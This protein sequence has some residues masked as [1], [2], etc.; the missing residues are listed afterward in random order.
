MKN[1]FGIVFFL[2]VLAACSTEKP[3]EEKT[4]SNSPSFGKITVEDPALTALIDTNAQIE[5][6]DSGYVWAEGPLWLESEKKIIWSD[7]PQNTVYEWSETGG[8]KVY[9][10]PSGNT[11]TDST[12]EGANGLLLDNK[13]YLIL[14]QHG[15]R[16]VARMEAPVSNPTSQ[17][18]TIAATFDG[19]RFNSPNDAAFGPEEY[20]FFTDPPYGL[21]QQEN[22]PAKELDFQGVY[23]LSPSGEVTLL[24]DSLTRPNGIAFSRDYKT[25]YVANSDPDKA[26]W[27]A[28]QLDENLQFSTGK[29]FFDATDWV[30]ER[31]G[32]PD[33][34]KVH[35]NGTVFATGP[36]GV[37][38]F[39]PEGKHLGTIE[40]GTA[41]ANCAFD[42]DFQYLYMTAD[43]YM[44]R[45]KL[46]T[47]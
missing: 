32:L 19:K 8:T 45:L 33:G 36:G 41:I 38:V 13:G 15:D 16:R 2:T 39:S 3:A 14:C 26:L 6:L 24:V 23:S 18:Q 30:P 4:A 42:S 28:Y 20:L 1:L 47:R 10:H 34:L 37:L 31:P 44:T 5:I 17:F 35:P 21:K 12:L 46:G 27:M 43:M 9:L 7:V 25:C 11:T 22:D 29:V 40:T